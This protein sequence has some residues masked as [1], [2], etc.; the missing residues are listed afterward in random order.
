MKGVSAFTG[1]TPG[2]TLVSSNVRTVR[3]RR[4][5]PPDLPQLTPSN[6][7]NQK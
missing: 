5:A 7:Q 3:K 2:S 1:E 6:L 4:L